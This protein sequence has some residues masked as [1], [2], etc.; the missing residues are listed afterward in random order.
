MG[1]RHIG[2]SGRLGRRLPRFRARVVNGS[3]RNSL[4]HSMQ[5][6]PWPH[7][8]STTSAAAL[9]QMEQKGMSTPA[10]PCRPSSGG[11]TNTAGA[12]VGRAMDTHTSDADE[13]NGSGRSSGRWSGGLVVL[14]PT[15]SSL[16]TLPPPPPPPPLVMSVG[17]PMIARRVAR[18]KMV[19]ARGRA[20]VTTEGA[21]LRLGLSADPD[22]L[23]LKSAMALSFQV[24]RMRL[25]F[26]SRSNLGATSWPAGMTLALALSSACTVTRD[27]HSDIPDEKPCSSTRNL[28]SPLWSLER[29]P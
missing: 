29:S 12:A 14:A 1:S 9:Q 27:G 22:R 16:F 18:A 8:L 2:H 15:T 20:I 24:M 10:D 5:S 19:A 3:L 13:G 23:L 11:P 7:G 28:S 26:L 6:P 4:E 21:L 17:R 25:V